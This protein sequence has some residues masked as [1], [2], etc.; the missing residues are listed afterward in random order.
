MNLFGVEC[1]SVDSRAVSF[2]RDF[3]E[4]QMEEMED[5]ESALLDKWSHVLNPTQVGTVPKTHEEQQHIDS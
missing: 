3:I 2:E 1:D 4:A 5:V